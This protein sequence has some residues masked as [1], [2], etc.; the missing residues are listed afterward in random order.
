MCRGGPKSPACAGSA[1]RK[2]RMIAASSQQAKGRVAAFDDL[3]SRRTGTLLEPRDVVIIAHRE[4]GPAASAGLYDAFLRME[5]SQARSPIQNGPEGRRYEKTA[6]D[7]HPRALGVRYRIP[8]RRRA[9]GFLSGP[10]IL[11]C[12]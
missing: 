4:S 5:P 7:A 11:A 9:P 10:A 3:D 6:L 8:H 12:Q 2:D 1:A